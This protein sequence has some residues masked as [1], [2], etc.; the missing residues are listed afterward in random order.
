MRGTSLSFGIFVYCFLLEL[1]FTGVFTRLSDFC[2][3][4]LCL[5][6]L[7]LRFFLPLFSTLRCIY[8]TLIH[9]LRNLLAPGFAAF[10]NMRLHLGMF[11]LQQ[12]FIAG[13]SKMSGYTLQQSRGRCFVQ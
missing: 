7:L 4:L 2:L 10:L 3:L 13:W 5:F 1:P 9:A 8:L 11:S 6:A 12:S